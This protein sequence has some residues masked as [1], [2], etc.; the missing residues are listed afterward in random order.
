VEC[1]LENEGA[2]PRGKTWICHAQRMAN[3]K[4]FTREQAERHAGVSHAKNDC[5]GRH[6]EKQKH[7]PMRR[8]VCKRCGT[9]SASPVEET[10]T[11]QRFIVAGKNNDQ[12]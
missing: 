6:N 11:G 3:W 12:Q 5:P 10:H 8:N 4:V 1:D 2:K 9:S 7:G